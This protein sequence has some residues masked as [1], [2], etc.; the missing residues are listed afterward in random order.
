MKDSNNGLIIMLNCKSSNVK[1]DNKGGLQ[2][3]LREKII[4]LNVQRKQMIFRLQHFK[5]FF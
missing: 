1:G 3:I 5:E 2:N 4:E